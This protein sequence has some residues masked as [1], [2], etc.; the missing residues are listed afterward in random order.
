MAKS[1]RIVSDLPTV[2]NT[3]LYASFQATSPQ[4]YKDAD[5]S[6]LYYGSDAWA[7]QLECNVESS[8][9]TLPINGIQESYSEI[10]S[11]PGVSSA[12]C[13]D[14]IL[15]TIPV[16]VF[17]LNESLLIHF[18]MNSF[19][20]ITLSI[21]YTNIMM[22]GLHENSVYLSINNG[23]TDIEL[24]LYPV[25]NSIVRY[26]LFA[27]F[28]DLSTEDSLNAA[29]EGITSFISQGTATADDDDLSVGT[30][31]PNVE[32]LVDN[33][34]NADDELNDYLLQIGGEGGMSV[35]LDATAG[36]KRIYTDTGSPRKRRLAG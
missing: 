24:C 3:Q 16:W 30:V 22:T 5:Q 11:E 17:V 20:N 9:V 2:E 7:L 12:P 4:Y 34:G 18:A 14:G 26:P 1:I 8:I 28:A 23:A 31:D 29:Y 10:I 13:N 36:V 35:H 6:L 21:P 27:S 32:V 15:L 25:A 33:T 19:G